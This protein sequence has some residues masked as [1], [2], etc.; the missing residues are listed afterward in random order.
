MGRLIKTVD[1]VDAGTE[2]AIDI[3]ELASASYMLLITAESGQVTK[4]LVK[5]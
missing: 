3:S 5:E 2:T 4:Q 1:L